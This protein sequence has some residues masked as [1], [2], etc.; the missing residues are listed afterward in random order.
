MFILSDSLSF[1]NVRDWY[2][3]K[4]PRTRSQHKGDLFAPQRQRVG[5]K[6]Q[7]RKIEDEEGGEGNKGKGICPR[8]GQ[9]IRRRQRA[10]PKGK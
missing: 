1:I 7:T 5:N 3:L 10:F 2:Q 6:R 8:G 9:R 4:I